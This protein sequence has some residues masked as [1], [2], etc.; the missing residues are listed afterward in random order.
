MIVRLEDDTCGEVSDAATG[1]FVRVRVNDE[2]GI[3]IYV[4]GIVAE[5]LED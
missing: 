3:M 2:N 1:D 4:T 5:I